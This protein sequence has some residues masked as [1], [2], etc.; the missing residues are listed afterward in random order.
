MESNPNNKEEMIS[1]FQEHYNQY[2]SKNKNAVAM[3]HEIIAFSELDQEILLK[4][5]FIMEDLTREYLQR[6]TTGLAMAYPHFDKHPHVHI[7]LSQN[8]YQSSKSIRISKS[9]F[10]KIKRE[11]E[12]IQAERYPELLN[13]R[14]DKQ[15]DS[16][17]VKTKSE[18]SR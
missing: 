3:Y 12:R 11:I 6:R 9:K 13:S 10:S 16:E 17:L 18:Q 8:D 4:H 7:L 1:E 5:P 2:H 14:I 15:L